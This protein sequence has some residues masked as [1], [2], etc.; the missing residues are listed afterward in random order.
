MTNMTNIETFN[1]FCNYCLDRMYEPR[2]PEESQCSGYIL[3]KKMVVEGI[4]P[5]SCDETF[6]YKTKPTYEELTTQPSLKYLLFMHEN[7]RQYIRD[8]WD[9]IS[10]LKV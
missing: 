8:N 10:K 6:R 7:T 3:L 5:A 2:L 4:T 1:D 9:F